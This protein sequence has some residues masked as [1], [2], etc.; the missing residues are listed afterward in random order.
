MR[1]PS[2]ASGSIVST[3]A[4]GPSRVF[5]T[6]IEYLAD[7]RLIE[8]DEADVLRLLGEAGFEV[9]RSR[10]TRDSNGL[11]LLADAVR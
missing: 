9:E 8:R 2:R 7:W 10:V 4:A 5:R 11:A 6:W 3:A 1:R